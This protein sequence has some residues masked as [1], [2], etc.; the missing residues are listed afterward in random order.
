MLA[1][2]GL[3]VVLSTD[4]VVHTAQYAGGTGCLTDPDMLGRKKNSGKAVRI[5]LA[6]QPRPYDYGNRPRF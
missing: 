5:R 2:R 6:D 3:A 1:T 4:M